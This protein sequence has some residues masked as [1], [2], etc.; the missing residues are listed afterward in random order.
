MNKDRKENEKHR[1]LK[2]SLFCLFVVIL[3]WKLTLGAK[4]R[5]RYIGHG[6]NWTG[7]GRVVKLPENYDE[8]VGLEMETSVDI[9]RD[10]TTGFSVTHV[11]IST[12]Y[13]R[14]EVFLKFLPSHL[15]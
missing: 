14:H 2:T 5:L 11:W 12:S 13:D 7:V 10:Q 8:E 15:F 9:P 3:V 1:Y 6:C 4:L